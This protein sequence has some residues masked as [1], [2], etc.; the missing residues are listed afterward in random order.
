[1]QISV[2]YYRE[3]EAL[4]LTVIALGFGLQHLDE[5]KIFWSFYHHGLCFLKD[6]ARL[7]GS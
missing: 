3:G 2:K 5:S 6:S 1:M 4:K 7:G